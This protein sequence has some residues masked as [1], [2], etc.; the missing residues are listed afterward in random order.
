[1]QENFLENEREAV[2]DFNKS[3]INDPKDLDT[4]NN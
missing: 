3:Q 1:M 4:S 2:L